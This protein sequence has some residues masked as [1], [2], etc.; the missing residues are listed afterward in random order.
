MKKIALLSAGLLL[1]FQATAGN[2]LSTDQEKFSYLLGINAAKSLQDKGLEI[3]N[4][5]FIL[6][7]EDALQG[8]ELKLTKEEMDKAVESV[9]KQLMA[10]LEAR[11]KEAAKQNA[12]NGKKY[13]AENAKKPGI[14]T[15]ESGIQYKVIKSGQGNSPSADDTIFAH[16]EG[17]LI[18]GKVF[19]SS[20]QRGTALKFGMAGV[21]PGWGEVL[22]IMK[23]GDKWEVTIPSN[24]A[25]GAKG[26]GRTIGPNETLIFI[27]EL[28]QFDKGE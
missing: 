6:G 9:Q 11:H 5:A 26:A 25:Y 3:D 22:K 24:L 16:Y 12:E 13:L 28:I 8:K 2:A 20:Y 4:Q 17:R 14:K 21:I 23:P 19:D 1:S 15:L 27:I 7:L 10:S 18:N